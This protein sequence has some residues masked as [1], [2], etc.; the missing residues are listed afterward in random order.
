MK[1]KEATA[2]HAGCLG[3]EWRANIRPD[4]LPPEIVF[5]EPAR[6]PTASRHAFRALEEHF[7][8]VKIR[9]SF[10]HELGEDAR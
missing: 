1:I 3:N 5:V 2:N 9:G 6:Q 10:A 4:L 8:F 7:S